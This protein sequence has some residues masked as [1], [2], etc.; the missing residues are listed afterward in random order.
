MKI[1]SVKTYVL[2]H[3]MTRATGPANHYYRVRTTLLI[4][5][6]AEDGFFGW[7]ETV[8]FPG[9]REIIERH[10]AP[11]LIGSDPREARQILRRL[12]GQNFGNGMAIGGVSIALD[13]LRGK[14]LGLP[15]AELYGGRL[16]SRVQ[17]YA[18]AMN[19]IEGEDPELQYPR[20]AEALASQ[21]FKA[22]KM[23][24]GGQEIPRD[25]AAVKA[26]RRAVGP[27]IKLMADGNGVY[28]MGA[29]VK[30]GR[31][32][33][34]Q[35]YYW[36]EEPLPQCAPDYSGYEELARQLDIPIAACEGLTAR[37]RFREAL[38]RRAMDIAQP[39][40]A[41]SGGVGEVL[42]IAEMAALWGVPCMPHCWAG[43]IVIA[44][45][46]HLVSLLPDASFGRAAE[47]PLLELDFVENPFREALLEEPLEI[48]DGYVAVST[49]PG[50]G[51][52]VNEEQVRRFQ[53]S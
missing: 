16:R 4:K 42:F 3:P 14:I 26:V 47:P 10:C 19:Y 6:E 20:E 5:I 12:W 21:G 23:R 25:A 37:G 30:M 9:V 52:T 7:G 28:T 24:I 53:V 2:S 39:D 34:E 27:D 45:S 40:V 31:I 33:E 11:I 18:S 1:R 38:E 51:I 15:V 36:Y 8:S 43:A 41:L 29:A 17:T 35:D 50:L 32:L 22:M 48:K 49:K 44:A 13:D 46:A